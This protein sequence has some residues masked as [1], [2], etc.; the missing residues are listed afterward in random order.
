MEE[1]LRPSAANGGQG[2]RERKKKLTRMA[3]RRE[4][5]RLFDEQGY[6]NTTVEQIA[7]A[8]EVSPR[9]IYR[10]FGVKEGLLASADKISPIIDAFVEAPAELPYVEA[11]RHAIAT[12]YD[13]LSP[14]ERAD[15][16][17]GEQLMYATPET[18]GLLYSAYIT[19][20]DLIANALSRRPDGPTDE[21]ERRV[22]AGAI[23]GVLM[24]TSHNTPVPAAELDRAL[25]ALAVRL[26]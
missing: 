25:S 1:Q 19:L 11:Y 10:Y 4:A 17:T 16:I 14:E 21:L 23:T 2:L 15:A 7:D 8:A 20:A 13:A 3:I 6:A 22:V 9:T 12:V 5:F 24:T 26:S 18:R